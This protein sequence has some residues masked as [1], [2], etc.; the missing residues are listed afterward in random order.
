MEI[1]LFILD[2]RYLLVATHCV[3]HSVGLDELPDLGRQNWWGTSAIDWITADYRRWGL[4]CDV[5]RFADKCV[6]ALAVP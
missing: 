4:R 2:V 3:R 6:R 5:Q 1:E